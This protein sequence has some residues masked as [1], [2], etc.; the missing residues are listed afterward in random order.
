M[1][2]PLSDHGFNDVNVVDSQK[3]KTLIDLEEKL[4]KGHVLSKQEQKVLQMLSEDTGKNSH[5]STAKKK[6]TLSNND[7]QLKKEQ[8]APPPQPGD[9]P[10]LNHADEEQVQDLL[11]EKNK[12]D[13]L[14]NLDMKED[15]GGAD[16]GDGGDQQEGNDYPQDE[17]EGL[18]DNYGRGGPE[19]GRED[20]GKENEEDNPLPDPVGKR[21]ANVEF[22]DK[23]DPEDEDMLNDVSVNTCTYA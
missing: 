4:K 20:G 16:G 21:E 9:S 23:G 19:G 3:Q 17:H 22:P 15:E 10:Q 11:D 2:Q 1:K 12:K 6:I 7:E 18:A 5:I 14:D 13:T 8:Q